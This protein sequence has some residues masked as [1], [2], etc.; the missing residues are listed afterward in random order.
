M[1]F[2]KWRGKRRRSCD[3]GHGSAG[4][5]C[6]SHRRFHFED[7][8]DL[9]AAPPEPCAPMNCGHVLASNSFR[10]FDPFF[11]VRMAWK[12]SRDLGREQTI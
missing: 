3:V 10:Q 11:E 7:S 9:G 1:A 12:A 4:R 2:R 5:K 6:S 8:A